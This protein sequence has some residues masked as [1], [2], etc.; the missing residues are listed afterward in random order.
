MESL[1]KT[2]I[3]RARVSLVMT[4]FS[5]SLSGPNPFLPFFFHKAE[6]A[7]IDQLLEEID[8]VSNH[9]KAHS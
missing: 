5:I 8:N 7:Y 6:F 1:L 4:E 9:C 3:G 2:N